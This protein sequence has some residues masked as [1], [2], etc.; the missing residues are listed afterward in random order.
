MLLINATMYIP[1]HSP[2]AMLRCPHE[3]GQMYN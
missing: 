1:K 3:T 2:N